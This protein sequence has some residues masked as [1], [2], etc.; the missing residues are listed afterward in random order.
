MPEWPVPLQPG[1][2]STHPRPILLCL[3]RADCVLPG[4]LMEQGRSPF[5]SNLHRPP[6]FLPK[7]EPGVCNCSSDGRVCRAVRRSSALPWGRAVPRVSWAGALTGQVCVG[8]EGGGGGR[9]E[10]WRGRRCFGLGT[11]LGSTDSLQ[12]N[13]PA[14]ERFGR[15][16]Q[17]P[18]VQDATNYEGELLL[19]AAPPAQPH[20]VSP[21]TAARL[22]HTIHAGGPGWTPALGTPAHSTH[23]VAAAPTPSRGCPPLPALPQLPGTQPLC[24][25]LLHAPSSP[26]SPLRHPTPTCPISRT[27]SL[28]RPPLHP[29]TSHLCP[30]PGA[31]HPPPPPAAYH[32]LPSTPST[33]SGTTKRPGDAAC[34]S[35]G[36][37]PRIWGTDEAGCRAGPPLQAALCVQ[38]TALQL[39]ARPSGQSSA[40][41]INQR[42]LDRAAAHT[43]RAFI[44]QRIHSSAVGASR[45]PGPCA[46]GGSASLC[47]GA[48]GQ[49]VRRGWWGGESHGEGGGR[50]P[51]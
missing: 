9:D 25:P 18:N 50:C 28:P 49:R 22:W 36:F 12:K 20:D 5:G 41:N 47:T 7:A 32:P 11:G 44:A 40:G 29:K 1:A 4:V 38:G 13:M 16:P 42:G 21:R 19:F 2:R 15:E 31:P 39:R 30:H 14:R 26:G 37:C 46:A 27:R 23:P 24:A 51:S 6:W 34:R 17:G 48:S 3:S 8:T 43:A 10:G 33:A 45:G 35:V